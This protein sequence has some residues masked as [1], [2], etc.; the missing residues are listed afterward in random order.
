MTYYICFI[1]Y[2][3][4]IISTGWRDRA[5]EMFIKS[6]QLTQRRLSLYPRNAHIIVLYIIFAFIYYFNRT[7]GSR[8]LRCSSSRT[9]SHRG[10]FPYIRQTP[11]YACYIL[12]FV[13]SLFQQDVRIAPMRCSSRHTRSQRRP[14][15][16]KYNS[17][18]H[19]LQRVPRWHGLWNLN[20]NKDRFNDSKFISK[21][22]LDS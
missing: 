10:V 1:Y 12:Y 7:E 14:P 9:S 11:V 2:V 5:H 18:L 21:I 15:H 13:L 20:F 8:P 4:I 22:L 17:A 6:Y 16:H 3:C 19:Y